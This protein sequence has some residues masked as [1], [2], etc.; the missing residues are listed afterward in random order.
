MYDVLDLNSTY[1]ND[2][3]NINIGNT[4]IP[5]QNKAMQVK[6]LQYNDVKDLMSETD[7]Y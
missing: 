4:Q 3:N 6:N 2:D 5:A 1:G 7:I